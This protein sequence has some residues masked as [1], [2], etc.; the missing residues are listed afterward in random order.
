[1]RTGLFK[2][3]ALVLALFVVGVSFGQPPSDLP[4]TGVIYGGSD[5]YTTTI[6]D[7]QYIRVTG[8]ISAGTQFAAQR[9]VNAYRN[10]FFNG[11]F[12]MW[13]TATSVTCPKL[14]R[15]TDYVAS[16]GTFTTGTAGATYATGDVGILMTPEKASSFQYGNP[17]NPTGVISACTNSTTVT[18]S[19]TV[20]EFAG[21]N[22]VL[23]SFAKGTSDYVLW[24]ENV[25]AADGD[26]VFIGQWRSI[27]SLSAAGVMVV[28]PAFTGAAGSEILDIG[29]IV[30]IR[31]W[32]DVNPNPSFSYHGYATSGSGTTALFPDLVGRANTILIDATI[33][34]V[35]D[36]ADGTDDNATSTVTGF[37]SSTGRVTF[38]TGFMTGTVENEYLISWTPA[39]EFLYGAAGLPSTP[40]G[41]QIAAGKNFAEGLLYATQQACSA[42]VVSEQN[43]DALFGPRGVPILLQELTVIPNYASSG[44]NTVAKHKVIDFDATGLTEFWL[45]VYDSTELVCTGATDSTLFE[46][47]SALRC[48]DVMTGTAGAAAH[49]D[50]GEFIRWPVPATWA[51]G[52]RNVQTDASGALPV[53][54]LPVDGTA[55]SPIFHGISRG[56][57]IGY[58][59]QG[60]GTSGLMVWLCLYR[61]WSGSAPVSGAGGTW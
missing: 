29:D 28:V 7:V 48:I 52:V 22:T 61:V 58:E 30:S 35:K 51:A 11:W 33:K 56:T 44:W 13:T 40:T 31:P 50:P 42:D 39:G 23:F 49:F 54:M 3:M 26:T 55:L 18:S 57:D 25:D 59:L 45:M 20:P 37:L 17:A 41:A 8:N 19:I 4:K 36:V 15:V 38:T 53:V 46:M 5:V 27:Y 24:V 60:A 21:L 14:V 6:G 34:C 1:M 32:C 10:D 47:G 12:I 2:A 43:R 16:T 9:Y